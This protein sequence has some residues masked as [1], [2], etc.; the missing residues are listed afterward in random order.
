L[1]KTQLFKDFYEIF[2]ER[3]NNKTNGITPRRWLYKCNH[4]LANLI[5]SRIGAEWLTNLDSLRELEPSSTDPSF[6]EGWAIIKRNNKVKFS[7]WIQHQYGLSLNPDSLFDVQVKRIHEYKRQLMNV[8]HAL[9]LYLKIKNNPS[10]DLLP[11]TILFAGKAAPAYQMAKLQIKLMNSVATLINNDVDC[12]GKLTVFFVPNY[13]VSLAELI[14]PATDLSEQISLAGTEASGTGNMKFALNGA[15]TIGTLD[16]ANIEIKEE[17]GA[18][19]IFI[20][21]LTADEVHTYK[22]GNNLP[23]RIIEQYE[24]LREIMQLLNSNILEPNQHDLFKPIYNSLFFEDPFLVLADFASYVQCQE[25][26][27]QAFLNKEEWTRKSI[28][29]VARIGKF[30]SDRTIMEYNRDIWKA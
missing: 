3:F 15:L 11:R 20:F 4:R 27:S 13:N 1:I 26:V 29:N 21:G 19:N 14:I 8:F 5:T 10:I 28:L 25:T 22:E 24:P 30:S 9:H 2:P 7:N 12:K 23:K 16:G 6:Q 17:V 18:D